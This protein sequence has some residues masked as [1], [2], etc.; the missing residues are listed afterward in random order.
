MTLIVIV[1]RLL[2][3]NN[4][5]RLLFGC[6]MSLI[7]SKNFD[8]LDFLRWGA[9]KVSLSHL[10][11]SMKSEM[12]MSYKTFSSHFSHLKNSKIHSLTGP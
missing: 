9:N 5:E 12:K 3:F 8:V 7:Y 4:L 2:R 11:K 1:I 10:E 6:S